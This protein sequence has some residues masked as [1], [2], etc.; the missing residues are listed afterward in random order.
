MGAPA[1]PCGSSVR[2]GCAA[3]AEPNPRYQV[4]VLVIVG[5]PDDNI[6]VAAYLAKVIE[7]Q[8]AVADGKSLGTVALRV[9][10]EGNYLPQLEQIK[11]PSSA[12]GRV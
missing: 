6:E 7:Q 3:Y 1:R 12:D 8:T 11:N 4:D 5:H 2:T 9:K 10:V